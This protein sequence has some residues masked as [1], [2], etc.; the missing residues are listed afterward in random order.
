MA[1]Q[2]N[3]FEVIDGRGEP[4]VG[5][6]SRKPPLSEHG[7]GFDIDE[8][9]G[10][11]ISRVSDL[12]PGTSTVGAVVTDHVRQHRCIDHDQRRERSSAMSSAA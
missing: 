8:V 6:R 4:A 7:D 11:E 5:D 1:I 2:V 3:R 10:G 12:A 9:G